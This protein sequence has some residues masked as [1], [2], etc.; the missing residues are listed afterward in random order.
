ML[1]LAEIVHLGICGIKYCNELPWRR[2]MNKEIAKPVVITVETTNL[3][4]DITYWFSHIPN[5]Y[6]E[7]QFRDESIL[8]DVLRDVDRDFFK[9]YMI[10]SQLIRNI[11]CT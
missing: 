2:G 7:C 10:R 11:Y 8:I 5:E 4:Y 1:R 9:K 3:Y 6:W